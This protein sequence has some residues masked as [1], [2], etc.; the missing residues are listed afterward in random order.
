MTPMKHLLFQVHHPPYGSSIGQEAV[1]AVLA[2]SVFEPPL[3]VVFRDAGVLQ[4]LSGQRSEARN[5]GAN[6]EALPMFG[7]DNVHVLQRSLDALQ[8]SSK[9]LLLP[10]SILDDQAY[11]VLL[12]SADQVLDY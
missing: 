10:A 11:R 5:A 1:E 7:V 9:D 6:W 12:H 8:L 4:L 2:A 3:D